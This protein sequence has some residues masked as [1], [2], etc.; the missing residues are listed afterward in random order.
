[1]IVQNLQ[2]PQSF[3]LK[4]LN[5]NL[6]STTV[7][8]T[9]SFLIPYPTGTYFVAPQDNPSI[10]T[11]FT[12]LVRASISVSSSHGLTSRSTDVFA[13]NAGF[14]AFF[15][16]YAASLASL[17]LAASASSSSSSEPKRSTS[18]SSSSPAELPAPRY[19]SAGLLL[20]ANCFLAASKLLMCKNHLSA[21]GYL[22]RSGD[23]P[24]KASKTAVSA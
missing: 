17:T 18:S 23:F 24:F 14:L 15:S 20:L 21:C 16:A 5:R 8:I 4:F 22:A 13:I 3:R 6:S 7:H 19:E 2:M 11:D 12:A 1:M 10:S 9:T